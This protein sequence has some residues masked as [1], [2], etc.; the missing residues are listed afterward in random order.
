[1]TRWT[2]DTKRALIAQHFLLRDLGSQTLDRILQYS[3]IKRFPAGEAIFREGD[4][5]DCL[6]GVLSGQVRI[7]NIGTEMREV[8]LNILQPGN[9]FGEVAL[10][11]DRPRTASASAVTDCELL[12]MHRHHFI[13]LLQNDSRLA[14]HMLTLLC[15]RVR[16]TSTIIEDAAFL[17]LPGRLA[18]RLLSLAQIHGEPLPGN[19]GIRINLRLSQRQLGAM[20]GASRE[21]VNKQIKAWRD[22]GIVD[23][24]D[25][26]FVLRKPS[27]LEAAFA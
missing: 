5:G 1:M 8:L 16:W 11:D 2:A 4:P 18:K 21:A 19:E 27:W 9:L 23:I 6:Y 3:I 17:N 13:P 7:F 26:L 24:R 25:G 15:D 14:V 20:V 10:I 22:E 12:T